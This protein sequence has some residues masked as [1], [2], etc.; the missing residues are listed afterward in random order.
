MRMKDVTRQTGLSEWTVRYYMKEGL[1]RPKEETRNGRVY[2]D[3]SPRDVEG[4][5]AVVRLRSAR[6][7]MEEIRTMQQAPDR[8]SEVLAAYTRRMQAEEADLHRLNLALAQMDGQDCGDYLRLSRELQ[9]RLDQE[10]RSAYVPELHFAELDREEA[11]MMEETGRPR[12]RGTKKQLIA[13][14]CGLA[15]L[16]A[17]IIA[18]TLLLRQARQAAPG[19]SIPAEG[20][21]SMEL[22]NGVCSLTDRTGVVSVLDLKTGKQTLAFRG[23]EG[24][25]WVSDSEMQTLYYADEHFLYAYDIAAERAFSLLDLPSDLPKDYSGFLLH[26]S[27]YRNETWLTPRYDTWFTFRYVLAVTD[28]CV[29]FQIPFYPVGGGFVGTDTY[30]LDRRTGEVR[31][32][33]DRERDNLVFDRDRGLICQGDT[34]YLWTARAAEGPDVVQSTAAPVA[35]DLAAGELRTISL[36]DGQS[37][38]FS[39]AAQRKDGT[40]LL[41]DTLNRVY[42]LAPGS[43]RAEHLFDLPLETRLGLI[44]SSDGT[45]VAATDHQAATGTGVESVLYRLDPETGALEELR[46]FPDAGIKAVVTDGSR[47][48]VWEVFHTGE[49]QI[50][51]GD[52]PVE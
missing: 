8:I 46:R 18:G 11:S 43:D 44:F 27:A 28:N 49:A 22:A 21:Q 45:L 30:S 48:G 35:V 41:C 23:P 17:L 33:L 37:G 1:V 25:S 5:N 6:F 7:S 9:T 31:L 4:L 39:F 50:L 14:A 16:L 34:V 3:F 52:L 40:I 13:T 19:D 36:P 47:W 2:S 15:L 42:G 20:Y 26:M 24:V 10:C 12:K 29:L 32:L 38:E 51:L